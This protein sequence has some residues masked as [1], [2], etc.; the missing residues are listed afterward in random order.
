MQKIPYLGDGHQCMMR[1][2]L[3]FGPMLKIDCPIS[4]KSWPDPFKK[5]A[6]FSTPHA[7]TCHTIATMEDDISMLEALSVQHTY[8]PDYAWCLLSPSYVILYY[9]CTAIN[10][11]L[12]ITPCSF[13]LCQFPKIKQHTD[14]KGQSHEIFRALLWQSSIDQAQVRGR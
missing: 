14:L 7:H 4:H 12:N 11:F 9:T 3:L 8:A 5:P 1:T 6:S 10:F 2:S 13:L